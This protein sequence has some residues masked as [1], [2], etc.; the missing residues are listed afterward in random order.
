MGSSNPKST[1]E[2]A[3][4]VAHHLSSEYDVHIIKSNWPEL[5]ILGMSEFLDAEYLP[6]YIMKQND[7]LFSEN[8]ECKVLS[9]NPTKKK[10]YIY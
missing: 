1:S 9:I 7:N 10:K 6:T 3:K 4:A 2:I 8:F 5:K